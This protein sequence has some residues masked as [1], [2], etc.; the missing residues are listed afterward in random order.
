MVRLKGFQ[1]LTSIEGALHLFFDKLD[2][3]QTRVVTVSLHEAL[4]RILAEDMIA[5][6]DLP[7]FDRS[8]VDG[9]AVKA[10]NTS[11]A[12]QFRQKT[13]QITDK[14]IVNDNQAKQVWT[15]NC[16]P[17]GADAVVMLENIK[18]IG[19]KIEVW[20]T[21]TPGENISKKGEDIQKGK[22]AVKAK[23]H[24]K[25]H[26]LGLI[27]ALGIDK[28]RVFEK[29]KIAILATGNELVELGIK[30]LKNQIFEVNRLVLSTLCDELGVESLDLGIAKDDVND[31]AGKIKFGLEKADA[32]I[33]TG[34]TSVGAADLV[35]EAVNKIG[36]PGVIV[37]GIAMRPA[38]PTAL[39]VVEG[40]PI[41]IL[42][43]NP[44]SA[45]IGFE[46]FARP[47]LQRMLGSKQKK[48]RSAV[49]AKITRRVTT[50]LGR[51]TFVRFH[52]H[53]H[54]GEF[55]AEPISARGSSVISSMTKA[56]GY[57]VVPENREGLEEG[58]CVSVFLFDDLEV[59]DEDV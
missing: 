31:I 35:P 23:T 37:H 34:G 17:G 51:K 22:V 9:Y 14:R 21:L 8:A 18:R 20:A 11:G 43:G 40:K 55:I 44:V 56:N 48:L 16:I 57:A 39:A 33:T 59:T 58:E 25:P 38:M 12:S 5:E 27:A 32:I 53:Q 47:L 45:M 42:S 54:N 7:R 4:N 3:E 26:H 50:A 19:S 6:E 41:I 29:P 13:L 1:K 24:L 30:P 28:V 36:K 52:V 10:E 49:K 15:G 46:V 2:V